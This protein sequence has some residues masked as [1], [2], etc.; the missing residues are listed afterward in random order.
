[1]QSSWWGTYRRPSTY[2]TSRAPLRVGTTSSGVL[3]RSQ[4]GLRADTCNDVGIKFFQFSFA[5]RLPKG[6]TV[7][8]ATPDARAFVQMVHKTTLPSDIGRTLILSRPS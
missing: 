4:M 2:S 6:V 3:I 1:M 8:K 7:E 5:Y